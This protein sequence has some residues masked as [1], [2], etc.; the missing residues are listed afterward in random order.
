MDNE[1][2]RP[3]NII[4]LPRE[5]ALALLKELNS[6]YGRR[7]LAMSE[8]LTESQRHHIVHGHPLSRGCCAPRRVS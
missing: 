8:L 6:T 2:D 7:L 3:E 1:S 5:E 4:E